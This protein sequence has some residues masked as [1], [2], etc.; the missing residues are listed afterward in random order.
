LQEVSWAQDAKVCYAAARF[1]PTHNYISVLEKA[2]RVLEAFYGEREVALG[3]L[4]T[5]TR[6][7]KSGV[8]RILFTLDHLG[9]IEKGNGGRYSV[10]SGIGRL[11]GKPRAAFDLS[12]LAAPFMTQLM[13]RFQETTNLGILEDGEVLHIHVIEC[14]HPLRLATHAGMCSPVHSTALSKCLLCRMPRSEVAPF[15]RLTL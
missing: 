10:S 9:Y 13:Q 8:F 6:Q 14:S 3:E 1:I 4:A 15:L 2:V 12:S 7:V 5:R 11:A